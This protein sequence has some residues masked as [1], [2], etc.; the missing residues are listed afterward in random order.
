MKQYICL[1]LVLVLVLACQGCGVPGEETAAPTTQATQPPTVTAVP[2]T[3]APTAP[4]EPTVPAEP[5]VTVQTYEKKY[6]PYDGRESSLDHKIVVPALLADTPDAQAI[7]AAILAECQK[8]IDVL[9]ADAEADEIYLIGYH[10]TNR[11][12]LVGLQVTHSIGVQSGGLYSAANYYYYDFHT[13]RSLTAQEYQQA[14]GLDAGTV[15]QRVLT[16]PYMTY[17]A[18][19]PLT[20]TDFIADSSLVAFSYTSPLHMDGGGCEALEH[21]VFE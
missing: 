10:Y 13:G 12:G 20:V 18:D 2:T 16:H 6:I 3:A 15:A 7:N 19:A 1:L 17:Y 5:V 8:K 9:K 11:D 4:T 21:N 14:L